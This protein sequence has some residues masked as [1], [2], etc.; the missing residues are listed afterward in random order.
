MVVMRR[1]GRGW[2]KYKNAARFIYTV[3]FSNT[4]KDGQ[5][6]DAMRPHTHTAYK[7]D[8]FELLTMEALGKNNA[9]CPDT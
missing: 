4:K 7:T 8:Q 9:G 3:C 6:E 5:S 2:I 1:G